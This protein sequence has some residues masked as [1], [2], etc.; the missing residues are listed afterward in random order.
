MA[1]SETIKIIA[2]SRQMGEQIKVNGPLV[3]PEDKLKRASYPPS[4]YNLR[5]RPLG[6]RACTV[7]TYYVVT[8][9][10]GRTNG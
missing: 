5:G 7:Q 6:V 10:Y 2:A 1:A 3:S 8:V 4:F 9:V